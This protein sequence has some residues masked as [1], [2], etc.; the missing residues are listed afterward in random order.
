MNPLPTACDRVIR[1]GLAILIAFTPLAF[2][3]V[4]PWSLA[5]M[6]WGV[7]TLLLVFGLRIL[8]D[9]PRPGSGGGLG[10]GLG[11]P[12]VLF[13]AFCALQTVP[14]P[15]GWLR[16]ISPGAARMYEADDFAARAESIRPGITSA[17]PGDPVLD[18]EMPP[19]RPVS[20]NPEETWER[21]RF[22]ASMAALFSLVAL[23]AATEDRI[24][25]L[26]GTLT[27][28]GFLVALF[29]L[30][31]FLTWNG[32]IYWVRKVPPASAFGPF[33]NHNHFSGYVEMV[34]PVALS[35]AF[36]LL[37][38]SRAGQ[39]RDRLAKE[40]GLGALALF[41][42]VILVVSLFFSM[43]RGG[44]LSSLLSGLALFALI[45]RR[46]SSRAL[47]VSV[48]VVLP[49][50]VLFMI[51][52]IGGGVVMRG[53]GSYASLDKEASFRLRAIIWRTALRHM[54]DYLWVGSGLGTFED[55]FAPNVPPGSSKRWDRAHNDYIQLFWEAG[56][57]G[58][59]ICLTGG[60]VFIR[61]YWWPAVR[62]GGG[63]LDLFRVGTAI[64]LMSIAIHSLVDFNLQIGA[65]GFLC[66]L[67]AGLLVAMH[68]VSG[69][70]VREGP[71][72]VA[73]RAPA[74]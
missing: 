53:L 62:S 19:R 24:L 4:E 16:V 21:W 18:I 67:L 25:G 17:D 58:A 50:L 52:W 60:Y 31:Q 15:L 13:L 68:R 47:K 3:T 29:G 65:N 55:S 42:A 48:G 34:I 66:A 22:A 64:S 20:V 57:I 56:I 30:V 32:R 27:V 45:W 59:L 46:I 74:P 71:V 69:A 61:R 40:W 38:T 73:S 41:A 49:L 36:Y 12:M 8:W 72:L 2:G 14:V 10:L 51:W 1:W 70:D 33:V 28:V 35:M 6:E 26:L 7:V 54:P 44:I 43:S 63:R 39:A 37:G 9:P 11:I 5:I 23:W